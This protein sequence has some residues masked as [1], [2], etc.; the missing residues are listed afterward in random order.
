MC[1]WAISRILGMSVALDLPCARLRPPGSDPRTPEKPDCQSCSVCGLEKGGGSLLCRSKRSVVPHW[2]NWWRPSDRASL[3]DP[4][5]P[6]PQNPGRDTG[7][8]IDLSFWA[9]ARPCYQRPWGGLAR[10]PNPRPVRQRSVPGCQVCQ[11]P[12]LVPWSSTRLDCAC[13]SDRHIV[14]LKRN[15]GV[16][17]CLATVDETRG[18][19]AHVHPCGAS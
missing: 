6:F 3:P 15:F 7:A 19:T 1:Q 2:V 14:S 13:R 18:R 17:C 4:F 10:G 9:L 8:G 12:C 5:L 16:C 11:R